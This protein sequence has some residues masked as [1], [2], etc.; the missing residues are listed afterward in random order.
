MIKSGEGDILTVLF[1]M[2]GGIVLCT[3]Y[4]ILR[5]VRYAV[6]HKSYVVFFEDI[7]FAFISAMLTFF[8]LY[9]RV[10]GEVRA[11]VIAS[12]FLGFLLMR[13]TFSRIFMKGT[14]CAVRLVKKINLFIKTR[15]MKPISEYFGKISEKVSK[16]FAKIIKNM[17]Q[18]VRGLLYNKKIKRQKAKEIK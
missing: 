5:T 13:L 18:R 14:K 2:L 16:F 11:F 8:I 15:I 10:Q 12:E 9:T 1:A 3:V 6:R 7:L 4:D 17:L